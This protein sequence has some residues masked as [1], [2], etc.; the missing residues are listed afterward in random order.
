VT[1]ICICHEKQAYKLFS[2]KYL[3]LENNIM[4]KIS[5]YISWKRL[6]V[7]ITKGKLLALLREIFQEFMEVYN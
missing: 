2:L 1:S 3:R 4:F 6:L 5:I 7:P